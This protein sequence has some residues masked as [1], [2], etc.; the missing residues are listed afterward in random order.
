MELNPTQC[1]LWTSPRRV[2]SFSPGCCTVWLGTYKHTDRD[3]HHDPDL[4]A[5]VN[6]AVLWHRSMEIHCILYGIRHVE[7]R[8]ALNSHPILI[9]E[10]SCFNA[11]GLELHFAWTFTSTYVLVYFVTLALIQDV[12]NLFQHDVSFQ[13]KATVFNYASILLATL[14]PPHAAA[15]NSP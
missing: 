10:F 1:C 13:R 8:S 2:Y 14:M 9:A 4:S 15:I 5:V 11:N 12:I 7:F 3:Q 6:L